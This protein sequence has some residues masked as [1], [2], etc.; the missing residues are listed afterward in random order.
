MCKLADIFVTKIGLFGLLYLTNFRPCKIGK[1]W[2][3]SG[4]RPRNDIKPFRPN[5]SLKGTGYALGS[6]VQP[7]KL[8]VLILTFLNKKNTL[9]GILLKK[10]R[11]WDSVTSLAIDVTSLFAFYGKCAIKQTGYA[12]GSLVQPTKLWVLILTSL[13]KKNTLSG[14]L[15]KKRRRWDSNPRN[16]CT[17]DSFQDCSDQPL[18]HS[19]K[20]I[21]LRVL[22]FYALNLFC[23]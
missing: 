23:Q 9:S 2:I 11:R 17:F 1:S 8:R 4:I 12:L 6:L 21:F 13:N 19:S 3:A 14:I 15:L 20:T 7:T 22:L 16:A 10:R 18:W 5:V